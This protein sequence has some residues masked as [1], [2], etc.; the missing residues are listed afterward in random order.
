MKFCQIRSPKI[1]DAMFCG[2]VILIMPTAETISSPPTINYIDQSQIGRLSR[3]VRE[4][5]EAQTLAH[6]LA[7]RI[8]RNAGKGEPVTDVDSLRWYGGINPYYDRQVALF[9]GE[10]LATSGVEIEV[11][12]VLTGDRTYGRALHVYTVETINGRC[13]DAPDISEHLGRNVSQIFPPEQKTL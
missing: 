10:T 1:A 12:E 5:A 9:A 8:I 2:I 7:R 4:R 13:L 11:N 3:A 6:N